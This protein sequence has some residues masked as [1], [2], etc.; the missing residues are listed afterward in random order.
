MDELRRLQA[1]LG[2]PHVGAHAELLAVLAIEHLEAEPSCPG[3]LLSA[4]SQETRIDHVGGLVNEIARHAGRLSPDLAR[5]YALLS[6]RLARPP[7]L[8]DREALYT[9]AVLLLQVLVEAIGAQHRAFRRG[10]RARTRREA[11][12]GKKGRRAL[13]A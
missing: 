11:I 3:D 13:G 12:G 4:A 10:L 1:A 6:R 9:F 5:A 2:H 8:T 7:R